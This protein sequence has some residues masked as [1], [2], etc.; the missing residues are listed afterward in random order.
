MTTNCSTDIYSLIEQFDEFDINQIGQ[1]TASQR[2]QPQLYYE[3]YFYRISCQSSSRFNWRCIETQLKCKAKCYTDGN[4]IG[5]KYSIHFSIPD[6]RTHNHAP[7]LSRFEIKEKRRKMKEVTVACSKVIS[8]VPPR[9]IVASVV[10]EV[11]SKEAVANMPTYEADRQ[12]INRF[13]KSTR[14]DYPQEPKNL[15]EIQLPEFLI[16]T[17]EKD[18]STNKNFL[19][20]DSGADDP[21]RF[22]IFSTKENLKLLENNNLFADGTFSIAP[23]YFEQVYTI[24]GLINGKCVPLVYCLLP[25][26]NEIIY[27][28]F[29]EI[30]AA[31]L[32]NPPKSVSSDFERAFL[33]A[34]EQVFPNIILFGC[35]FHYK[36]AIWRKIQEFGLS[37]PYSKCPQHRKVLKLA[38]VLAFVPPVDV[39]YLFN[40][41]K[42]ELD[43]NLEFFENVLKLFNYMEET[44]IGYD[45]TKKAGRGRGVKVIT[46]YV[47]PR[48]KIE[49]WNVNSRIN[50]CLPR[51]NN[52]VEAW[53]NAFSNMLSKHPSIYPLVDKFRE[54]QKKTEDLLVK[55]ETGIQYKRKPAYILLDDRIKE[56]QKN[57]SLANFDK[58]YDSLSLILDY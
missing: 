33:N 25:K 6:D 31:E 47:E 48:F 52:S 26:K 12:A 20:H 42:S 55:L 4:L 40:K 30:I 44:W 58:Y 21:N 13:K 35:F 18:D 49:L 22:F 57:Y 51:T 5:E 10:N 11:K 41:I 23:T 17:L 39:K 36:Q 14:P 19:L 29:L 1:V 7:K 9:Q 24:H 46:T 3:G 28:K 43:S 15:S 27:V 45:T 56:I 16:F 37:V 53:H 2:G 34:V 50:D 8:N 32:E 54:E 38:Q